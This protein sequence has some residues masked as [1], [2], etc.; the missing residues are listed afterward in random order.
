MNFYSSSSNNNPKLGITYS[1]KG[2]WINHFYKMEQ[3]SSV[4]SISRVRLLATP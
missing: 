1:L 2:K 4:Q 3:F